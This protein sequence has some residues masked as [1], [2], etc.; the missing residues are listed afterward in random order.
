M[1]KA[2]LVC[3]LLALGFLGY[4]RHRYLTDRA[5][6]SAGEVLTIHEPVRDLGPRACGESVFV[7][8]RITNVSAEPV[9]IFGL[10][11]G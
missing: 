4:A 6:P 7:R 2:S 8:F 10:A 1:G 11:P 5:Q 3:G 9:R